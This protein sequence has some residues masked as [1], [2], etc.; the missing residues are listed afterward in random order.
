MNNITSTEKKR[1]IPP[2]Q[3]P[4][5]F[6]PIKLFWLTAQHFGWSLEDFSLSYGWDSGTIHKW[7][8]SVNKPS[9]KARIAAY[10]FKKEWGL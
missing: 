6:C 9:S 7:L 5:E 2:I 1:E 3:Q 8:C 10:F 4:E